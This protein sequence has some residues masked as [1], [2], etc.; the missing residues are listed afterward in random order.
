MPAKGPLQSP[1]A[2]RHPHTDLNRDTGD[3]WASWSRHQVEGHRCTGPEGGRFSRIGRAGT[4]RRMRTK[5]MP[6]ECRLQ[7]GRQLCGLASVPLILLPGHDTRHF[8][9]VSSQTSGLM[10]LR[11]GSVFL[12][13][14][15]GGV[16]WHEL[17]WDHQPTRTTHAGSLSSG[18][19][20]D[21]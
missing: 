15:Q 20:S 12:L 7:S 4:Q 2:R 5:A 16:G 8:P 10:C 18:V 21:S 3:E 11:S 14:R 9:A 1:V 17:I 13:V 6:Q 19:A